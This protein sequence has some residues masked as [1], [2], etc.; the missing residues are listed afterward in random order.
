MPQ[1]KLIDT[2]DVSPSSS[3]STPNTRKC[4]QDYVELENYSLQG[5]PASSPTLAARL[6]KKA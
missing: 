5:R 2:S 1:K 4:H 6:Q 3:P